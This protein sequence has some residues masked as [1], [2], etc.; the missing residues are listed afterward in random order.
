MGADDVLLDTYADDPED[1][2][3]HVAAWR[4]LTVMAAKAFDLERQALRV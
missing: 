4:M 3:N 1:T 2:R